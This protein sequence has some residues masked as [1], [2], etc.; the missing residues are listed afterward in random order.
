M[1]Y[2]HHGQLTFG[3]AGN[4]RHLSEEEVEAALEQFGSTEINVSSL[5]T[6][7]NQDFGYA[8]YVHYIGNEMVDARRFGHSFPETIS[9]P[10]TDSAEIEL[11]RFYDWLVSKDI[12]E[13]D[14]GGM[15]SIGW[16]LTS[17]YG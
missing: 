5:W 13:T 4:I 14:D 7:W 1:G 16:T 15:P 12:G 3:F 17:F 9:I 2:G 6:E 8:V 10:S 11:T